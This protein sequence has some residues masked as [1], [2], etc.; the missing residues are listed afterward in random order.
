MSGWTYPLS[1]GVQPTAGAL[2]IAVGLPANLPSPVRNHTCAERGFISIPGVVAAVESLGKARAIKRVK[3]IFVLIE[4]GSEVNFPVN[5]VQKCGN[6]LASSDRRDQAVSSAQDG[7]GRVFVRLVPGENGP[8]FF[9][10]EKR[11]LDPR[12]IFSF[13]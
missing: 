5:N 10:L 7:A 2:N 6:V 13:L 12:C 1:S 8:G 9:C 4:P 11:G 3:E